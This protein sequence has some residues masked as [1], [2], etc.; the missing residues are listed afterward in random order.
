MRARFSSREPMMTFT[1]ARAQRTANPRPSGPVP[2][3]MATW[4]TIVLPEQI[5]LRGADQVRRAARARSVL[6]SANDARG[7]PRKLAA[8]QSGPARQFVSG[9]F[10]ADAQLVAMNVAAVAVIAKGFHAR[11]TDRCFRQPFAPG[12]AERVRDDSR[13]GEPESLLEGAKDALGGRVGIEGQQR[14]TSSAIDIRNVHAAVGADPSVPRLRDQHTV[15]LPEDVSAFTHR[16]FHHAGI[17]AVPGRPL[18]RRYA[19][20]HL[21]ERDQLPFRFRDDLMSNDQDVAGSKLQRH[22]ARG[23]EDDV[24]QGVAR[25]NLRNALDW[26]GRQTF[27]IFV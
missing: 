22:S 14:G 27:S 12:T 2:P 17:V 6:E 5:S 9:G 3:R 16:Q 19:R 15:A 10:Q 21:G 1:P 23:L 26:N 18:R 4:S 11:Q 13:H 7:R 25:T 20:A 8:R 24:W